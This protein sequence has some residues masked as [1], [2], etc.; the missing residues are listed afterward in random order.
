MGIAWL[1]ANLERPPRKVQGGCNGTG[2]RADGPME[3]QQRKRYSLISH[4]SEKGNAV[5]H[6]PRNSPPVLASHRGLE[7][8]LGNHNMILHLQACLN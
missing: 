1:A 6:S 7:K 3:V 8:P 5:A 4:S 2:K